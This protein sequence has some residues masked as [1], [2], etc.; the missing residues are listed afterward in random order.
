VDTSSPY[1][2]TQPA[3]PTE[4]EADYS[5]QQ[6]ANAERFLQLLPAPWNVGRQTARR[7]APKLLEAADAQGWDLDQALVAELTK[8][9]GGVKNFTAVLKT[10]IADLPLQAAVAEPQS[11]RHASQTPTVDDRPT[12]CEDLD[13][14]RE[15]RRR[16]FTDSEGFT[17]TGPCPDCHPDTQ[18]RQEAA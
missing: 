13:C 14:D 3:A 8:N 1:P 12:W 11:A 5:P 6:I 7:Q 15:T 9:P 18:I 16:L 10:R 4:E 2:L 17:R